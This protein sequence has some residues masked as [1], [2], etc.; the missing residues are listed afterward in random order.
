MTNTLKQKIQEIGKAN[1]AMS[2][3]AIWNRIQKDHP[4][5]VGGDYHKDQ[6]VSQPQPGATGP[7]T[8]KQHRA[9]MEQLKRGESFHIVRADLT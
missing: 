5:L 3:S 6:G 9:F 8:L 2:F 1:P 7:F 4:E